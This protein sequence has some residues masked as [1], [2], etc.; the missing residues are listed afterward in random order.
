[1]LL[2][3]NE[4]L[5]LACP[6]FFQKHVRIVRLYDSLAQTGSWEAGQALIHMCRGGC[7]AEGEW[8]PT[9]ALRRCVRPAC[10]FV[11]CHSFCSH[12]LFSHLVDL[13][14]ALGVIL[15]DRSTGG[16]GGA[17]CYAFPS[18]EYQIAG[19]GLSKKR[20]RNKKQEKHQGLSGSRAHGRYVHCLRGLGLNSFT[21]ALACNRKDYSE[22][23]H[24]AFE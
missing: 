20:K 1:M 21:R 4:F 22:S 3:F 15:Q 9:K 10:S 6:I 16:W 12:A 17:L 8:S 5:F 11:A 2:F 19:E 18:L 14:C 23:M 24:C 13:L 7:V